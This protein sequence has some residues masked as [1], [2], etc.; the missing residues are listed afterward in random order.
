MILSEFGN[1]TAGQRDAIEAGD[2]RVN[3]SA[4]LRGLDVLL[5]SW[6]HDECKDG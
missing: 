4:S 6:Q 2:L 1:A 5:N 3:V